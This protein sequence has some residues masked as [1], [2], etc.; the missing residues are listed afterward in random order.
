MKELIEARV[1]NMRECADRLNRFD[2]SSGAAVCLRRDAQ[3][4]EDMQAV[5]DAATQTILE[6]RTQ[7][8]EVTGLQDRL[9][10]IWLETKFVSPRIVEIKRLADTAS[11]SHKRTGIKNIK[12]SI[13]A[14]EAQQAVIDSTLPFW[15]WMYN[16]GYTQGHHDTVESMYTDVQ[17]VDME[18]YHDDI[19]SEL[20]GEYAQTLAKLDEK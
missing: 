11:G 12:D 16:Q 17:S 13:R 18:T 19:V 1:Q 5:I 15:T 8:A 4:I 14:L 9:T 20:L 6:L 3:I 7:T 2:R 10:K